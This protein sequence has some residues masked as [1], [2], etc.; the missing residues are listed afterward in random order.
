MN[1]RISFKER[2]EMGQKILS[3]KLPFT[4]EQAK[5]QVLQMKEKST[6]SNR[7]KRD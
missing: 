1:Y 2:A 6:Q 7:K 3:K 5:K 4:L